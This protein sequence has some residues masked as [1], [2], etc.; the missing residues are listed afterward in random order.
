VVTDEGRRGEAAMMFRFFT[1]RAQNDKYLRDDLQPLFWFSRGVV[2]KSGV[3]LV[4]AEHPIATD[5][6]GR[7]APLLVLGRFG[8]GRTLFS[9]IDDSWRWRYYTGESVFDTYWVQQIRY[10]AR[11]RS[12]PSGASS[13]WP[14]GRSTSGGSR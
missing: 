7:K 1:D 8:A 3:G 4:Y 5:P 13:S 12:W 2:A 14:T 9:A 11:G 6:T 10:L